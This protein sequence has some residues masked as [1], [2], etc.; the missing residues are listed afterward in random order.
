MNW[1]HSI[2][3]LHVSSLWVHCTIDRDDL[4][5]AWDAKLLGELTESPSEVL[6][7]RT[8]EIELHSPRIIRIRTPSLG[9]VSTNGAA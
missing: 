7:I 6:A 5:L 1:N 3:D 8:T 9:L 2:T 4:H